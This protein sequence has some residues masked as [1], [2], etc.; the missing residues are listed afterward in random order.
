MVEHL[1]V[2]E[3]D[4]FQVV[5]RQAAIVAHDGYLGI[6]RDDPVFVEITLRRG[7]TTEQ[8]VGFY[9]SAAKYVR[10]RAGVEPRN[11]FVGLTENGND[12]WS[13]GNGE[14]QYAQHAQPGPPA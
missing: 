3:D 11:L 10:E 5:T 8:K 6:H 12:D 1:N 13:F 14:A 7:R 9:R 2:P 4:V